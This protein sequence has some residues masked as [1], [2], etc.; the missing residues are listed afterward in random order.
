MLGDIMK[1]IS[2]VAFLMLALAACGSPASVGPFMSPTVSPTVSPTGGPTGGPTVGPTVSQTPEAYSMVSG[3]IMRRDT[4]QPYPNAYVRFGWLVNASYEKETHTVT[5]GS[6]RYEIELPAGQYQV[7]AGDSCDL[8]A[9]FN[10]VGKAPDDITITVP[11]TSEVDFVEYPV[12][13]GADLP[14]VC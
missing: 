9:G 4:G 5:D 13:P 2:I 6:G 14:G 11:G 10:I 12:T 3:Q 1:R 7:T 8:N